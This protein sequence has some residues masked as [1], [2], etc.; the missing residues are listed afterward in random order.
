MHFTVGDI[1]PFSFSPLPAKSVWVLRNRDMKNF[2]LPP[3]GIS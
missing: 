1:G 2:V 3:S